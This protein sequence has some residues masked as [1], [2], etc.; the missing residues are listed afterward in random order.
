MIWSLQT[1]SNFQTGLGAE[2]LLSTNCI[3]FLLSFS[4]FSPCYHDFYPL[5]SFSLL[6]LKSSFIFRATLLIVSYILNPVVVSVAPEV[7]GKDS[8]SSIQK[9]FCFALTILCIFFSSFLP[10]TFLMHDPFQVGQCKLEGGKRFLS[11]KDETHNRIP[12]EV[13]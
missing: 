13:S 9:R 11:M 3:L 1:R 7:A 4:T 8:F 6:F 12:L 5:F 10:L 2:E